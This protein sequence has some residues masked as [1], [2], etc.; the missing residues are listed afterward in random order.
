MNYLR[1]ELRARLIQFGADLHRIGDPSPA[2]DGVDLRIIR[3]ANIRCNCRIEIPCKSTTN[4]V[5]AMIEVS[6]TVSDACYFCHEVYRDRPEGEM[7]C[8]A[9]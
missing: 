1:V 6:G 7:R 5:D 9:N 4:D 3:R 8:L 2:R